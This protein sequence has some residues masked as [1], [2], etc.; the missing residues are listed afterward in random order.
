MLVFKFLLNDFFLQ[1]TCEILTLAFFKDLNFRFN[2]PTTLVNNRKIL[3]PML[4]ISIKDITLIIIN[5]IYC[6]YSYS[7]SRY[8]NGITNTTEDKIAISLMISRV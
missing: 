3:I 5:P 7:N 4:N 6:F 2:I 1:S 8:P